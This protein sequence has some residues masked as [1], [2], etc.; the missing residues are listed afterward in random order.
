[1]IRSGSHHLERPD[2]VVL[3]AYEPGEV[4]HQLIALLERLGYDVKAASDGHQAWALLRSERPR[5]LI[6]DAGLPGRPS[7]EL[8]DLI[9]QSELETKV[10]LV[11]SV[12]RKTRYKRKPSSLYG[13]DDYV[14]QHHIPDMLPEKLARLTQRPSPDR[15]IEQA[16]GEAIR[17][18]ADQRLL[19]PAEERGRDDHRVSHLARIVASDMVLY[20]PELLRKPAS[21]YDEAER[22]DLRKGRELFA[23]MVS[24]EKASQRDFIAEAIDSLRSSESGADRKEEEE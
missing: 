5:A 20:N 9:S 17:R 22:E 13:A 6:V 18:T 4:R 24:E 14:E 15:S 8:C 7:Y 16:D 21:A 2:A 11:A 1:M 10:I 3:V 23:Q 12:Y 19:L